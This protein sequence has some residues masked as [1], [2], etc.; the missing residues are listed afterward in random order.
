MLRRLRMLRMLRMH[1]KKH[2]HVL[3]YRIGTRK[4]IA[5]ICH[6]LEWE[7]AQYVTLHQDMYFKPHAMEDKKQLDEWL[8]VQY[9][10]RKLQRD[11]YVFDEARQERRLFI[12]CDASSQTLPL[13][14][15]ILTE[16]HIDMFWIR[17]SHRR[18]GLG[19][20]FAAFLRELLLHKYRTSELDIGL[21]FMSPAS[22]KFW[23]KQGYTTVLPEIAMDDQTM[24]QTISKTTM[25]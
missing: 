7:Q 1:N 25:K 8:D 14:F 24:S 12:C 18:H 15:A 4:D 23:Q 21:Q 10:G 6:D 16:K 13:G 20:K 9:E 17:H 3:A 11:K 2:V 19:T 5:Q 22:Q